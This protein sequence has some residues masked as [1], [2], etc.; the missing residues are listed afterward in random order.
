MY[1]SCLVLCLVFVILTGEVKS[2]KQLDNIGGTKALFPLSNNSR[3]KP[4]EIDKNE[5]HKL[6][7]ELL[8]PGQDPRT[9]VSS[10]KIKRCNYNLNEDNIQN[11][12]QK[13]EPEGNIRS[14]T[15][16]TTQKNR[17]FM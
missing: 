15:S 11:Y 9:V 4:L 14:E 5:N 13:F 3:R 2:T 17:D 8:K 12:L 6:T 1:A 7:N 10:V 16:N